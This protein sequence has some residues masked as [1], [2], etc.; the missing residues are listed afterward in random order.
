MIDG[1]RNHQPDLNIIL[2]TSTCLRIS[3]R[4]YH[5]KSFL[6]S[7]C[8]M[9]F[10]PRST[11]DSRGAISTVRVLVRVERPAA[12]ERSREVEVPAKQRLKQPA[13]LAVGVAR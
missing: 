8:Q 7:M 6:V 5:N 1:A 2:S 9:G 3:L 12:S 4:R 11:V 10:R 13:E